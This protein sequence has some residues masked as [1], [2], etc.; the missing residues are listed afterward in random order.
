MFQKSGKILVVLAAC[1]LMLLCS[2]DSAAA[3]QASVTVSSVDEFLEA[4]QSNTEIVL[5]PGE[6]NLTTA[7]RYGRGGGENYHW[8]SVFDGYELILDDIENLTIRGE[9]VFDVVITTEP[10][11]ANVLSFMN[12]SNVTIADVTLGHTKEPGSCSG[13]VLVFFGSDGI[14]V[15]GTRMYGCGVRGMDVINSQNVH[16]D[17]SDIYECSD[18][19]VYISG[20]YNVLMEN[21]KFYNCQVWNGV[22][23]VYSSSEVA[24]INSEVYGNTRIVEDC[25][26]LIVSD[27]PSVYLGGLDVHNNTFSYLFDSSIRPVVMEKCRFFAE[28]D[29]WARDLN[30]VSPEGHEWTIFDLHN[31]SMRT[32]Q[33]E[34]APLPVAGAVE[35]SEDGKV[36]VRNVDEFLAAINH[37]TTIF[38]EPGI[39]DLST[40]ANYGSYG[41]EFYHWESTFDGP[42]L[43]INGVR[44]LII[45]GAGKDEVTITAVPR[46]ANVLR[47]DNTYGLILRGFTA[48]H[49]YE[50]GACSGGVLQFIFCSNTI[51]EGCSL[52]GCGIVG[53]WAMYCNNLDVTGTEIYE[54][55]SG[56]AWFSNCSHVRMNYCDVHDIYGEFLYD[57]YGCEDV[58]IDGKTIYEIM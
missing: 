34:P 12:A 30:P 7:K 18:G 1:F 35:A 41:S 58:L 57:D 20:S 50:Q 45:E 44:N 54:C 23:E 47:F 36:H 21:S 25:G 17:C 42:E 19:C 56:A 6:Y 24:F 2:F 14:E 8:E 46:Y 10:R 26:S 39:Y 40:A 48:G 15:L 55:S 33:W 49:T 11:Y 38:L 22:F 4:L 13:G 52:Y 9:N 37:D 28:F 29:N 53:V 27:C 32:V 31:M 3:E 51:V 43:V 5:A 16:V